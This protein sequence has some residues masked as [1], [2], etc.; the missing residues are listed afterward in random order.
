MIDHTK[1]KQTILIIDDNITNLK[2][3]MTYLQ[4][5]SFDIIIARNGKT[6]LQR[7]QSE[8]PD[9]ILLDVQM[10]DL[11]GF[12]TCR[13][14]KANPE[15]ERIP[16]IFMTVAS[17]TSAKVRGLA[18]GAVDYITKPFEAAELLARV[19]THL[20][21][22]QLQERLESLV[23]ERTEALQIE[24]EQRQQQQAEKEQL[25]QTIHQQNEQFRT[26]TQ[27]FVENQQTDTLVHA[28]NQH[29]VQNLHLL[30]NLI[31]QAKADKTP[32]NDSPHISQMETIVAH[33]QT[34]TN[35]F[36]TTLNQEQEKRDT[37]LK[38][39]LLQLSSRE[40]EVMQL[41]AEGKSTKDIAHLL[42]IAPSTASTYRQR[43]MRKLGVSDLM[44]LGRLLNEYPY[45]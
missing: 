32:T 40:H 20:A 33:M 19:T 31:H 41:L 4:D 10:P 38:N 25:W 27:L 2:T 5:Y 11:D 17:E 29:F 44:S 28:L 30:H 8:N 9:L 43:I 21:L 13:R 45:N 37:F 23:Q 6:G 14:L 34:H 36:I 26:L 16:V 7:A 12:E 1:T 42:T 22:Y 3:A 24:I 15:T 18:V 39:P 35:T